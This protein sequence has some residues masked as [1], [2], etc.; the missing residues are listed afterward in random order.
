MPGYIDDAAK[1]Y[2]RVYNTLDKLVALIRSTIKD[3]TALSELNQLHK[4]LEGSDEDDDPP[5][6]LNDLSSAFSPW[7]ISLFWEL[8]T[9]FK[10]KVAN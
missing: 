5:Q 6:S 4:I 7:Q 10:F 3:P 2:L 8:Q 9:D 1:E